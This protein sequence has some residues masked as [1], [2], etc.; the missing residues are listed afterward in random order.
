MSIEVTLETTPEGFTLVTADEFKDIIAGPF[1]GTQEAIDAAAE[2]DLEIK[3][4]HIEPAKSEAM[5]EPIAVPASVVPVVRKRAKRIPN[6]NVGDLFR[7]GGNWYRLIKCDAK[8]CDVEVVGEK[9][10]AQLKV[11]TEI[12]EVSVLSLD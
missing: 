12:S 3:E 8:V 7:V 9:S 11:D 4:Q 2:L 5:I 1:Q 10:T 6:L